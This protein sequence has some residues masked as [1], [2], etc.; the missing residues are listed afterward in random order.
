MELY[1]EQ[2]EYV[3]DLTESAGMRL[4]VHKPLSMAFPEDK[5]FFLHQSTLTSIALKQVRMS[6]ICYL[7]SE[8]LIP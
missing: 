2:D 7:K 5:G 6:C 1:L 8:H 3:S 4:V